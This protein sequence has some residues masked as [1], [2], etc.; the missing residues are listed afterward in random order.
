MTQRRRPATLEDDGP[1]YYCACSELLGARRCSIAGGPGSDRRGVVAPLQA[2]PIPTPPS[3]GPARM[4]RPAHSAERR[5]CLDI[6]LTSRTRCNPQSLLRRLSRRVCLNFFSFATTRTVLNRPPAR[7]RAAPT[8]LHLRSRGV[9]T[10]KKRL[11]GCEPGRRWLLRAWAGPPRVRRQTNTFGP[12]LPDNFPQNG[13]LNATYYQTEWAS[14][15][16]CV[17]SPTPMGVQT[18]CDLKAGS[19]SNTPAFLTRDHWSADPFHWSPL[20]DNLQE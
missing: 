18:P 11:Q 6:R 14:F 10:A 5:G 15:A 20:T 4:P 1:T 7:V 13:P 17:F 3:L 16:H 12:P 19:A 8:A 9:V 2:G